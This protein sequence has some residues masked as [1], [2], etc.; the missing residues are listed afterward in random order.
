VQTIEFVHA[1]HVPVPAGHAKQTENPVLGLYVPAGQEEHI[2]APLVENVPAGQEEHNDA[3]LVENV[4]KGHLV[5]TLA[6]AEEK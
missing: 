5:Q 2:D 1:A 3:P 6:P 4:P